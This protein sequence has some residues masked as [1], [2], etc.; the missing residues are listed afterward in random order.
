MAF[1]GGCQFVGRVSCLRCRRGMLW[2]FRILNAGRFAISTSHLF[3]VPEATVPI[4]LHCETWWEARVRSTSS[5]I[6]L[7]RKIVGRRF[8][9]FAKS[10]RMF[11]FSK[12]IMATAECLSRSDPC[13]A[14]SVHSTA[15][16]S[17]IYGQL[18]D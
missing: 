3:L 9:F 1:W 8:P 12:S 14:L 11:C 2:C 7:F 15:P 16:Q 10:S 4:K 18:I 5:S 17:G 13:F 6:L